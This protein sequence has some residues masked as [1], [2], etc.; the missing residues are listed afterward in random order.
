MFKR[1]HNCGELTEKDIGKSVC[2][3]GWVDTWRD[4]GGLLFIDLRDREGVTQTVFNPDKDKGLHSESKKLRTEYVIAVKGRVEAR[5]KDMENRKLKTGGIEVAV[6]EMEL[7]NTSA[8]SPFEISDEVK[9]SDEIKLA[10]R[11][12]DLRRPAMQKNLRMRHNTAKAIRDFLHRKGFLDVDTPILTKSTPE[13]ARDYLV[14]SRMSPGMFYALPQSPQLFK[15]ILMVSGCDRYFQIAKCFRDEDLRADR[16]PEFTQLDIEMSFVDEDDIF[17]ISER[18]MRHVFKEVL[19][20]QIK[21]PFPRLTYK[22]AM[23]S[24]GT[25]KPDTRFGVEI[26]DMSDIFRGTEFKVFSAALSAGGVVLGVKGKGLAKISR[27]DIDNLTAFAMECGAKGL[28]YFKFTDKGAESPITK[29][30]EKSSIEALAKRLDCGKGDAAFLIADTGVKKAQEA[31]GLLRPRIA[32][33]AGIKPSEGFN[34][35]WVTDFPLFKYNE[36]EKRWESEHHPFTSCREKDLAFL[37]KEPQR[38]RA[39]AYDLVVNGIELGSGSIRIHRRELQERFF[40]II[41]ISGEEAD[42]RFGF[43]LKALAYG[44]PPHGGIAFGLD[45]WLTLYTGSESI[46]DVIA[47]PKTQ[48]AVCPMTG[49]PSG[50]GEKQLKEL[51]I[52]LTR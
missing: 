4:H 15:Q 21:T 24:Y 10:Y 41:G 6:E 36:D 32:E 50:I 43:L 13:G 30:F 17:D 5:P 45:R 20:A 26:K 2:L 1:T 48:K 40:R 42:R 29:F 51:N 9:I 28:A 38:A 33:A 39:R 12:L 7:L 37:E 49:A 16:Q 25:D 22:E 31:M 18:L 46:R 8:T 44:A 3:A 27:K 19:G 11:Y 34:F 14:P 52:K 35:L 23:S 47:F